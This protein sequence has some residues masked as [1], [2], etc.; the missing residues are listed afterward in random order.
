M[1]RTAVVMVGG[2]LA[3]TGIAAG[4]FAFSDGREHGA[5]RDTSN[6]PS[7]RASGVLGTVWVANE[8]SSSLTGFDASTGRIVATVADMPG[9]HNVQATGTRS[10]LAVS[11]D[12]MVHV[13]DLSTMTAT[14]AA[15]TGTHPAHVV[16][17]P[18][19]SRVYV[20]NSGDDTVSIFDGALRPLGSVAVG[21]FPHGLRPSPDGRWLLVANM[22]GTTASLVDTR[23]R[24]VAAAIEVG[25]APVQTAFHPDE[26]WAYV[27]LNGDD[28]IARIDLA[29]RKVV[30]RQQVDPGP[31]QSFVTP[32]GTRIVVA[33]Q[34][35]EERP[36]RTVA[37]LDARTLRSLG[38][39]ETGEGAHGVVVEPSSR[40]AY[41]TNIYGATT[42]IVDLREMRVTRTIRTGEEPNGITFAPHVHTDGMPERM[43]IAGADETEHGHDAQA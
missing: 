21:D 5:T 23:T 32:D 34:G 17:S 9:P 12:S 35:T 4:W 38:T 42:S 15:P 28:E 40:F 19:G 37:V 25:A 2:L 29:T 26:A 16:A 43:E 18:D 6:R 33:S 39:I 11:S 13:I 14:S 8:G 1:H 30:A 36:S 7:E 31:V 41:V 27:T 20:S 22:G 3:A 24:E 10:V